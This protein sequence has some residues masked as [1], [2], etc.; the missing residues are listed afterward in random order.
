MFTLVDMHKSTFRLD[1]TVTFYDLILN[2]V[3]MRIKYQVVFHSKENCGHFFTENIKGK[4]F[5]FK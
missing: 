3:G 1:S 4:V 2:F 5:Y